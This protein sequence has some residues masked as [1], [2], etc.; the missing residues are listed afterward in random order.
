MSYLIDPLHFCIAVAPLSA[1][2]LLI[3]AMNIT[4]RARVVSGTWDSL[5]LGMGLVGF[6]LVGPME[7]FL[8]SAT[9]FRLQGLVWPLLLICYVLVLTL[10]VLLSRPRIVIYN[11][12]AEQ[13]RSVLAEVFNSLDTDVRWAGDSV[14][15]PNLGVQLH[16]DV[17]STLRNVQLISTS[18]A[19]S[20]EGW[21][22]LRKK[23][24]A[25]LRETPGV[26][27]PYGLSLVF[28][29]VLLV[30]T[31]A[32]WAMHDRELVAQSFQEMIHPGE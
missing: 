28:C 2:L 30:A 32:F 11:L 16:V 24:S 8:P 17:V 22:R 4:S 26:R 18:V 12:G 20:Y 27:N 7:L 13:V 14:C 15:L 23:L 19:Q 5:S 3:G 6:V 1:Y 31:S 25:R 10:Y 29:G 9:A 21:S